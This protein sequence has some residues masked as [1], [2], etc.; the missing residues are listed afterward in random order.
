MKKLKEN[1]NYMFMSFIFKIRDLFNPPVKILK[2]AD[3]KLDDY[4]LD[5][6]CGLGSYSIAAS[7]LVGNKGKR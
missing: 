3:I 5:F 1:T 2:E 7:G 4:V 6:G